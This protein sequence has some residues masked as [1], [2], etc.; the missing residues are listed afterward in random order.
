MIGSLQHLYLLY[1]IALFNSSRICIPLLVVHSLKVYKYVRKFCFSYDIFTGRAD[2]IVP[3]VVCLLFKSCLR[4]VPTTQALLTLIFLLVFSAFSE[5]IGSQFKAI[6]RTYSTKD[7]IYHAIV[8]SNVCYL[9]VLLQTRRCY[10][11]L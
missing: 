1:L 4:V 10:R 6:L 5:L 11:Y 9:L 2:F 7:F 3:I 8:S